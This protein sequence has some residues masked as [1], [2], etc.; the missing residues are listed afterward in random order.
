MPNKILIF[1]VNGLFRS[2]KNK[3][4]NINASKI[5]LMIKL[6]LILMAT[7][8]DI[9]LPSSRLVVICF[10]PEDAKIRILGGDSN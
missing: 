10:N 2:I 5:F 9:F 1:N 7:L 3:A 8:E 4:S 6:V